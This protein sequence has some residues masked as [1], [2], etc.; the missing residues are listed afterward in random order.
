MPIDVLFV[1]WRDVDHPEGG[2]SER[3]VHRMAAGLG[4]SGLRV[5][6]FCAAHDRAPADEERAG[7]RIVRGGGR[8]RR[9][10]APAAPPPGPRPPPPPGPPPAGGRLAGRPCRSAAR[11]SPAPR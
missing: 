6:L 5:T 2:G 7:V 10:A 8:P 9:A 1:N 4:A 3:Y 11:W